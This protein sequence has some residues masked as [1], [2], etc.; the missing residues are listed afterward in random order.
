ML[1]RFLQIPAVPFLP[2]SRG[3]ITMD[4]T[5]EAILPREI[6]Q[7]FVFQSGIVNSFTHDTL[8]DLRLLAEHLI[9]IL[10]TTH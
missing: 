9:G 10:L 3:K 5:K 2:W 1:V 7:G 8:Q 6:F 4:L